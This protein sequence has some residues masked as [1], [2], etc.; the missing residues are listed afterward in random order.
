M[1]LIE[2]GSRSRKLEIKIP[3]AFSKLYRTDVDWGDSTTP[4]T[5]LAGREIVF[6]RGRMLGG[7]AAMNAMMV[8]RGHRADY[9]AWAAAGCPGWSWADVEPV[10]SRSAGARFPL[11]ELPDR[12][13][14]A[15]AFVHA[16]QAVGIP[17]TADLNAEDNSGV[18]F[19][20]VSQRRGRRF[21]VLD[22]YLANAR[23][24]PNLTIVTEA[25]V[26]RVVIENGRA[27][28]CPLPPWRRGERRGGGTWQRGSR[29]RRGDRLASPPPA[30]RDRPTRTARSTSESSSSTSCP[31]SGRTSST[32]WRTACS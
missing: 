21:S 2:A 22:G 28:R 6:P 3:A 27:C 18:G 14:L 31:G 9:D 24:R 8:L 17:F 10:F 32:T 4:Q 25:L 11:A 26:T 20:P 29:L 23:R 12:H 5:E 19:V 30:V 16:A 7:S 13:V 15:E 1:L